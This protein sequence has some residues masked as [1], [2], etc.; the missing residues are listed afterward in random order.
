MD[1]HTLNSAIAC[2]E[3]NAEREIRGLKLQKVSLIRRH[4]LD[5]SQCGVASPLGMWLFIE[6][7]R[8]EGPWGCTGGDTWH[9]SEWQMCRVTCPRCRAEHIIWR[10]A[11]REKILQL[12][13]EGPS[14]EELFAEVWEK[15][16]DHYK[17]IHPKESA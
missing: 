6:H 7:H 9:R 17:R 4:L 15:Y 16:G 1:L 13:K 3:A 8:Y 14:V 10:H 12:L 5:C 2:I 11:A